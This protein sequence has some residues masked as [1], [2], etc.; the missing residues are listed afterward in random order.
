MKSLKEN[1]EIYFKIYNNFNGNG[2]IE[3][4]TFNKDLEKITEEIS[5]GKFVETTKIYDKMQLNEINITYMFD[6]NDTNNQ[7]TL[8]G[9]DFVKRNKD[10]CKIK[11][12]N[13][14]K[15]LKEQINLGNYNGTKFTLELIGINKLT[16]ISDMFFECSCLESLE[17]ISKWNTY[18]IEN[19]NGAFYRCKSL[20]QLNGISKWNTSKVNDMSYMFYGCESLVSLPDLSKWDTSSTTKM[21]HIFSHCSNLKELNCISEW[22]IY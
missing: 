3:K 8:F 4:D 9:N 15:D 10:K 18:K 12:N 7:I 11:F 2:D 16:D 14:E 1:M 19:M 21:D 5:F 17:G 20:H 22:D 6:K 13:V